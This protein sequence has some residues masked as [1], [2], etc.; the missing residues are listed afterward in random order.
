MFVWLNERVAKS[1]MGEPVPK[2]VKQIVVAKE[3]DPEYGLNDSI[4]D[5]PEQRLAL[6]K[7]V[8]KGLGYLHRGERVV[9]TCAAGLS[10]SVTLACLVS[11]L[12]YSEKSSRLSFETYHDNALMLDSWVLNPSPV[13]ALAEELYPQAF[14]EKLGVEIKIRYSPDYWE[15]LD[16]SEIWER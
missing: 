10:R 15:T 3:Y 8:E 4:V 1:A 11:A 13:R 12:Y 6:V 7:A 14:R 9:F 2:G 5:G 16:L